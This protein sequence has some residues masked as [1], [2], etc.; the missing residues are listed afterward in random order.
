[1]RALRSDQVGIA[2]IALPQVP[3]WIFVAFDMS[4]RR[5][6]W[7]AGAP[8]GWKTSVRF[9]RTYVVDAPGGARWRRAGHADRCPTNSGPTSSCPSSLSQPNHQDDRALSGGRHHR[10]SRPSGRRSV[11]DRSWRHRHR[12][13]QA[14]GRHHARRRSGGKGGAGWLHAADGDLDHAGHQQ[15]A[16]QKTTLRSGRILRRSRWWRA[17]RSR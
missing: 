5:L 13:E 11:Q 8:A 17:C 14:R 3:Y 12:R 16:L 4:P 7:F 15:D 10:F 1:M 9:G 2:A 6:L